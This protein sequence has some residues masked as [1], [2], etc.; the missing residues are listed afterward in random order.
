[1]GMSSEAEVIWN[2][3]RSNKAIILKIGRKGVCTSTY[4]DGNKTQ[5]SRTSSDLGNMKRLQ[6]L[7][8]H[9]E[10]GRRPF[11]V[12]EIFWIEGFQ[13]SGYDLREWSHKQF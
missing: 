4:L 2:S 12:G 1:M 9:Q 5:Y 6:H 8:S 11:E 13:V 10:P 3:R 7:A